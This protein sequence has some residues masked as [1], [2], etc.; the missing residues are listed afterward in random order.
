MIIIIVLDRNSLGNKK[1][2]HSFKN[3]QQLNGL[4]VLSL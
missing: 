2:S 1:D 4:W 3:Q